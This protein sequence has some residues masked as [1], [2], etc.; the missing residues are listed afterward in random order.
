MENNSTQNGA[1]GGDI[2]PPKLL[3]KGGKVVNADKTENVDVL[4]ENGVITDIGY[5]LAAPPG[6]TVLMVDGMFVIPGGIDPHTHLE[7]EFMGTKSVDDFYRGTRAA[8]AGG[9]TMVID[10][11]IAHPGRSLLEV[12]DKYRSMADPKVCCD[13]GLHV[14]VTWWS[15]TV[16]KEM[17]LLCGQHGVNSFKLFMAYKDMFMV[18]DG[19]LYEA[20]ARCRELGA[21]AM[22]H[23]ENGHVIEKNVQK[24]K[25]S[26]VTGPEGH[27]M[28]RPEE[29][30][31]EAV[32]RAAMIAS[33]TGSPLYVVHVMSES[34]A[35]IIEERRKAGQTTLYGEALAAGLGT[36]APDDNCPFEVAAAH[37]MSPPLRKTRSTPLALMKALASGGLQTTG[38]DNCTFNKDQKAIG[39]NDFT[40]IPNGLNGLEDRMSVI[41]H[42]GVNTDIIDPQKFVEITS[43]NAAKI[44]NLYPKKGCI[45][46]GSDAD[47]VVWN[48]NKSKKISASTHKHACDFNIFEGMVVRGVPEIVIV[49]GKVGYQSGRLIELK[50]H[51]SFV[52]CQVFSPHVYGRREVRLSQEAGDCSNVKDTQY[53]LNTLNFSERQLLTSA[54]QKAAPTTQRGSVKLFK[55][56]D[57]KG[58]GKVGPN[59]FFKVLQRIDVLQHLSSREA[60]IL[61]KAFSAD[62][63]TAKEIA[64]EQFVHACSQHCSANCEPEETT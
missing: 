13:Y 15:R 29:V 27:E 64:Y 18:D 12:Y 20:F 46:V 50:G 49:K 21:V 52:P 11:A 6:T 58:N 1:E 43:T 41:W 22:V 10:F 4:V 38:T 55:E 40:K 32:N 8:V 7:F 56:L 62:S 51:G 60:D 42:K 47:I 5:D 57:S 63:V 28:S 34:A 24:L 19:E 17:E 48:P 25:E 2:K 44:F 26:G 36:V 54:L 33:Q 37:V 3:L 9:T 59:E 35:R 39:K 61:L 45:E 53:C 23:A 14:G 16:S 30:E 31:A